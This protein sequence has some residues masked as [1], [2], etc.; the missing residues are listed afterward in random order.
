MS[1]NSK[2]ILEGE[3]TVKIT[4]KGNGIYFE[5]CTGEIL[6]KDINIKGSDYNGNFFLKAQ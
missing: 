5:D 3:E 1:D 2:I 6:G 4:G